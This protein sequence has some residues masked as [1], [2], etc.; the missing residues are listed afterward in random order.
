MYNM[1]IEYLRL[2]LF[3]ILSL[4]WLAAGNSPI[5][6]LILGSFNYFGNQQLYLKLFL[7]REFYKAAFQIT[8]R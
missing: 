1:Y 4:Y 8:F 3:V 6:S 7:F 2:C 5:V